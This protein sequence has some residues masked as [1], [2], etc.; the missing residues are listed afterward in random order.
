MTSAQIVDDL[1]AAAPSSSTQRFALPST[2]QQALEAQQQS[3]TVESGSQ[4]AARAVVLSAETSRALTVF[5]QLNVSD[6]DTQEEIADCREFLAE[7]QERVTDIE[8]QMESG[9]TTTELVQETLDQVRPSTTQI[10]FGSAASST[11][12]T[13]AST[14]DQ[15]PTA[16]LSVK[17]KNPAPTTTDKS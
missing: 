3:S 8:S 10:G 14:T 4:P 7:M 15:P 1:L 11:S 16:I 13:A 2:Y 17:R 6:Q 9:Q 5:Q 12:P